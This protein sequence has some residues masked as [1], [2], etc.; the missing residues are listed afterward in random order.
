[1]FPRPARFL[2]LICYHSQRGAADYIGHTLK[3]GASDASSSAPAKSI[4]DAMTKLMASAGGKGWDAG[5]PGRYQKRLEDSV[6]KLSVV[7]TYLQ[8]LYADLTAQQSVCS[9]DEDD[10]F[11]TPSPVGIGRGRSASC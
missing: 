11:K 4:D 1:V 5:F 6:T 8:G 3:P 9:Q 10:G 7:E 2:K